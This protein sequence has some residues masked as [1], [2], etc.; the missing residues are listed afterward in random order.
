[1]ENLIRFSKED[2]EDCVACYHDFPSGTDERKLCYECKIFSDFNIL[3]CFHW[4]RRKREQRPKV[5]NISL[6]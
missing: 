3:I 1:M 5:L 6:E 2:G 4:C